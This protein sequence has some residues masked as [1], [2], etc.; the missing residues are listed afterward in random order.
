MLYAEV[1]VDITSEA[2]DRPFSYIIPEEME[3]EMPEV[4]AIS[5]VS[6]ISK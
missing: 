6:L 4:D 1:I 3:K 2:L 5:S